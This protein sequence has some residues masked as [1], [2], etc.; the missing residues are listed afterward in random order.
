MDDVETQPAVD[1]DHLD[2]STRHILLADKHLGADLDELTAL[3]KSH[4]LIEELLRDFCGRSVGHPKYLRDARL[5][6]KQILNLARSIYTL[7][8][9][10][11]DWTWGAVNSLNTMRNLMAHAIEPDEKKYGMAR[12]VIIKEVMSHTSLVAPEVPTFQGAVSYLAGV[13]GGQLQAYL[14]LKAGGT[15]AQIPKSPDA[16]PQPS[17]V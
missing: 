6:F 5:S 17:D 12:D 3:L 8:V 15:V 10:R 2:I 4:L 9:P 13:F 11:L 16:S 14:I 7:N 1:I